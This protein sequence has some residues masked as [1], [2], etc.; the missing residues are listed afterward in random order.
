MKA[1]LIAITL[2]LLATGVQ[3][4]RI[5]DRDKTILELEAAVATQSHATDTLGK[6]GQLETSQAAARVLRAI[7]EVEE[8]KRTLPQGTGPVVMNQFMQAVFE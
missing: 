8:M 4:Y 2:G 3:Q 7:D 6:A 1:T 5:V